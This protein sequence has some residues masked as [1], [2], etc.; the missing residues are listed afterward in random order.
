MHISF[1]K[2][3]AGILPHESCDNIAWKELTVVGMSAQIQIRSRL[4]QF[5]KLLRLMI[6]DNDRLRLI[7]ILQKLFW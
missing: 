5:R 4:C 2:I 1:F 6:H 3:T 7:Q